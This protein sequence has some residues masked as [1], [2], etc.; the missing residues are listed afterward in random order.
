ML[1]FRYLLSETLKSQVAVFLVLMA[2]FITQK[3]V[4]VLA[5]ATNGDIPANTVLSF[6]SLQLPV[7]AALVLPLSLFLGIMLAH[8]RFY[9][10]SEMAVMRACGISEWYVTRVTLALGG[11][12]A[13]I[14]AFLTLWLAP[15][16]VEQEY[17]LEDKLGAET[18]LTT[19]IP[20]R[21]QETANKQAV[22]FV[23]D[24]GDEDNQLEGVFLVRQK[25]PGSEDLHLIYSQTGKV[26]TESNGAQKL[27]LAEGAQYEGSLGQ[28][29]FQVVEF[30]EYQVQIAEQQ[31]EQQRRKL[32]AYPT[33]ELIGDDSLDAL[34]ELQWRIA[35]PLSIP[36]LILIA[37]P[38]SAVEPRQ[39]R[40]GK[41]FPALMLYLGYF[42]LLM[43]GRKLLEDGKI[44]AN[45]GLWWVHAVMLLIGTFLLV[46]GR[47]FG[48]RIRAQL[49]GRK[50]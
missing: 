29:D 10:D 41:M 44:P 14:T 48:V 26:E 20:G 33:Q 45:L 23:H 31:T 24:I 35:I 21:F 11:L 42:M 19:L 37:V 46:R 4:R 9:A 7:L 22:M 1:I 18:G 36:F 43:A 8:G 25:A 12:M 2:I 34:A 6:L 13:L 28:R 38:L 17:Q 50:A 49:K 30:A 32:T 3:F 39:G 27:V 47:T 5:E 40:F 16:A 15:L